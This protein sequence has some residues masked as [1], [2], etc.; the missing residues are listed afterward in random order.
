M[1]IFRRSIKPRGSF[2]Y[3]RTVPLKQRG[4]VIDL[5]YTLARGAHRARR[6][7]KRSRW[8]KLRGRPTTRPESFGSFGSVGQSPNRVPT[9]AVRAKQ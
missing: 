2:D 7:K 4:P 6:Q 3:I 8:P 5:A 1:T 9:T